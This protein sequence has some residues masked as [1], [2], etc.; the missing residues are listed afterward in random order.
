MNEVR[1]C[2][3]AQLPRLIFLGGA[4]PPGVLAELRSLFVRGSEVRESAGVQGVP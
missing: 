1:D 2:T 4:R 3:D